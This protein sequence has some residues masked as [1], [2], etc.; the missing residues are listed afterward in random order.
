[1]SASASEGLSW[2]AR[3]GRA[4]EGAVARLAERWIDIWRL[5]LAMDGNGMVGLYRWTDLQTSV[6]LGE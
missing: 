2:G 6:R 5:D 1:M 4:D 3:A